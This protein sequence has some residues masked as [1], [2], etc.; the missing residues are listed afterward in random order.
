MC[1]VII[2]LVTQAQIKANRKENSK[3][4]HLKWNIELNYLYLSK[5]VLVVLSI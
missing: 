1:S 4:F 5:T 2:I 3:R